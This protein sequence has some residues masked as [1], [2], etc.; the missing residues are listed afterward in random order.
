MD[1]QLSY[2]TNRFQMSVDYFRSSQT[3]LI[4]QDGATFPAHYYNDPTPVNF[5]GGEAESKYYMKRDWF[6]IA[7]ALYQVNDSGSGA[8]NL[9][10]SPGVVAKAGASYKSAS[11]GDFSVFDA[12]Q[13]HIAGYGSTL[14][15]P[16]QAVHSIS[17]HA[18]YDLS[19]H[20]LKSDV[21]GFAL[22][23]NADDL[24]NRPVWLPALGSGSANTLPLMRGRTVFF[25]IETWQKKAQ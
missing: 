6:L 1:A 17:A 13:G 20:W 7:S 21:W 11:G 9:S 22:F 16:A 3:N 12:F 8:K 14:N 24:L 5:Q 25:G 10:P 2:Q 15:P 18:R 4:I 19:K 23:L